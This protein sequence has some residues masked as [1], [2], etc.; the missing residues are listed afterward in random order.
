MILRNSMADKDLRYV[1][2][3][4][5]PEPFTSP[6]GNFGKYPVL[7]RLIR[8]FLQTDICVPITRP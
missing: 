7:L 5:K 8:Q 3:E 4:N 6:R 2:F 1:I